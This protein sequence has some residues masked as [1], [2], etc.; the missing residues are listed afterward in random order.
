MKKILSIVIIAIFLMQHFA[1]AD[2][3]S[4]SNTINCSKNT[5]DAFCKSINVE[6]EQIKLN[7]YLKKNYSGFSYT[8]TNEQ[9]HP[10]KISKVGNFY[11]SSKAVSRYKELRKDKRFPRNLDLFAIA[12]VFAPMAMMSYN[13]YEEY[14]FVDP[15]YD[16]YL[17]PIIN[18]AF[19]PY[20]VIKD[21]RDDKKA[22]SESSN[23]NEKIE[24]ITLQ[25][26]ETGKFAVLD[27]NHKRQPWKKSEIQITIID[28]TANQ[29]YIIYK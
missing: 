22:K 4:N 24:E 14:C 21:K 20:L 8:I 9:E 11:P 25:K 6:K 1:I 23:F 3:I 5:E 7:S 13:P 15:C 19:A 12:V 27:S 16:L 10:V 26:D 2:V 18:T 28:L 17:S 29:K